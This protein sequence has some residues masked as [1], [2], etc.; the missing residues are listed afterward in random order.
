MTNRGLWIPLSI[1]R[2]VADAIASADPADYGETTTDW[3]RAEA[4]CQALTPFIL[5]LLDAPE[6]AITKP[7]HNGDSLEDSRG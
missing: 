6:S 3:A 1:R 7:T 5:S 2:R 4:A